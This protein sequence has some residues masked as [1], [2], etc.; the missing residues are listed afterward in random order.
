MPGTLSAAQIGQ[1]VRT[2][3]GHGR[4]ADAGGAGDAADADFLSAGDGRVEGLDDTLPA[5]GGI[6]AAPVEHG[7]RCLPAAYAKRSGQV[8]TVPGRTRGMP[9]MTARC[10]RT[11][12]T[13]SSGAARHQNASRNFSPSACHGGPCGCSAA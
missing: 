7:A 13:A 4:T 11:V 2:V 8:V 9:S 10:R 1:L 3:S 12:A 6:G 5:A